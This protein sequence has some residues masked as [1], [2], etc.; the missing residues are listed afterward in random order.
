MTGRIEKGVLTGDLVIRGGNDPVLTWARLDDLVKRLRKRRIDPIQGDIMIDRGLYLAPE[1]ETR[2]FAGGMALPFNA[3]PDSLVVNG[4]TVT[5]HFVADARTRSVTV[6]VI[7]HREYFQ[8][9]FAQTEEKRRW[10]VARALRRPQG[11]AS[12]CG[13]T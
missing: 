13:D 10:R 1:D 7:G 8:R 11:R 4:K 5:V 9:A 6:R 12:S 3:L 2:M